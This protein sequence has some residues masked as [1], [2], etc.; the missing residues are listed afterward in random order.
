MSKHND[1]FIK[2]PTSKVAQMAQKAIDTLQ[3]RRQERL[4]KYVE[5]RLQTTT[6]HWWHRLWNKKNPTREEMVAFLENEEWGSYWYIANSYNDQLYVARR[7]LNAC[8]Q[9]D[10]IYL[11]TKDLDNIL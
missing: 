5:E 2:M 11:S 1:S 9:A 4:D 3:A 7:L 6:N 10:E 8:K